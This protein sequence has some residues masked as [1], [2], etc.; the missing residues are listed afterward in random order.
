MVD[1]GYC[2]FLRWIAKV[3]VTPLICHKLIR[4]DNFELATGSPV[5]SDSLT[6]T[7]DSKSNEDVLVVVSSDALH[8]CIYLHT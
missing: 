1:W 2:S 8:R 6:P 5:S 7:S 4:Y 3:S